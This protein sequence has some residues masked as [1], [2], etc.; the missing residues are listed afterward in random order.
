MNTLNNDVDVKMEI[1]YAK[2]GDVI[3]ETSAEE[4]QFWLSQEKIA[5]ELMKESEIKE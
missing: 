5:D 2:Y 3:C 1:Q 4:M